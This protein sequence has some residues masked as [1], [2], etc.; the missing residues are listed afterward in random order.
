MG[1]FKIVKS[2]IKNMTYFDESSNRNN[3]HI[4]KETI[5]LIYKSL[6]K[7]IFIGVDWYSTDT[8]YYN[9]KNKIFKSLIRL[10]NIGSLF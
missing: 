1:I 5:E 7:L 6:K 2:L 9:K 3:K 8:I 10:K 4:I